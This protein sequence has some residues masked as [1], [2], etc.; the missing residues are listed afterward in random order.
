[1]RAKINF[2]GMMIEPK[3]SPNESRMWM[4]FNV[5]PDVRGI[6]ITHQFTAENLCFAGVDH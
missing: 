4:M 3:G 6:E 1:V 5:E 2:G